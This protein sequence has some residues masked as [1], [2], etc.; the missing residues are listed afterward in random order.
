MEKVNLR[1][2][3][4]LL[5]DDGMMMFLAERLSRDFGR[6]LL[7]TPWESDYPR[8]QDDLIGEGIDGVERISDFWE[9]VDEEEIDLF[10][11]PGL[12]H[13]S[14]QCHLVK[15]GK[16]VWG[17]K[18]GD[19]LE[20]NRV[21]ANNLF[22]KLK[23]PRPEVTTVDGIDAL[24]KYLKS[25]ENVFVKVSNYRKDFETFHV[26]NYVLIEPFLDELEH[27]L[28]LAKKDYQFIIEQPIS[29][30]DI[31]E[32][33]FDSFCINGEY[34][35]KQ[36]FG[37]E[38]KDECYGAH[39]RSYKNTTKHVTDFM[40]AISPTLKSLG[41][42]NWVSTETRVGKKQP[43]VVVDFTSRTP[44]PN[45]ELYCE[46]CTN[47]SEILFFGAQG[48]MIQPIFEK[49]YGV[50]VM[51]DSSFSENKWQAVEIP[52][53]ISRW[54]KLRNYCVIDGVYYVIPKYS[55]FDNVGAVVAIGDSL[56]EC[57]DK[58]KEYADQIKGH[59]L[60]INIGSIEKLNEVIKKGEAIGIDF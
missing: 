56:K 4:V 28:G 19:L 20:R 49:K 43:P 45:F 22:K 41:Y 35:E 53:K 44:S 39:V 15:I 38:V 24:R 30:K 27:K 3:T 37:Y 51:I 21:E 50:E 8:S 54:V 1:E 29:G 59:K 18:H 57:F 14:I 9:A 2:K 5:F 7:Y 11:F 40:D 58:I 60:D 12:Y 13:A 34:P 36:L 17:S 23:Q 48:K 52:K 42:C 25:H 16:N 10:V 32:T 47:L 46:I 26:E 31:V 55:D 6:V 33:G